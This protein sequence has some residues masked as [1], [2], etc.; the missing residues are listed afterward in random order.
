MDKVVEKTREGHYVVL[1][2]DDHIQ[3]LVENMREIDRIEVTCFGYSPS[4]AVERSVKDSDVTFTVL[5]KDQKVMA[6]F[7]AGV[8]EEA[9]IWLLGTKELDKNPKPFLRHCRK[10]V[11]SLVE[12]YGTVSNWVHADNLECLRW[13]QWCGAEIGD[14]ILIQGE[15]LRK[16]NISKKN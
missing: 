9:F 13:L 12:M 6:I 15:L 16:F 8:K 7:G 11:S 2:T 3:D 14:P 10:W 4:K 1:T 5:S